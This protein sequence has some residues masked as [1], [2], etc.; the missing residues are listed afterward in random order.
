[1]ERRASK[2]AY[3]L[4]RVLG[5]LALVA[6]DV[7]LPLSAGAWVPVAGAERFP[8]EVTDLLAATFPESVTDRLPFIALLTDFD[9]DEFEKSLRERG[10]LDAALRPDG[11]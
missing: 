2:T 5:Y 9:V 4:N 10:L 1:M 8:W 3:F 11:G 7:R 6:N